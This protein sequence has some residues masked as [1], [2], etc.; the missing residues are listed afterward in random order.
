MKRTYNTKHKRSILINDPSMTAWGY[1]VMSL[2]GTLLKQGCIKTTPADKMLRIRKGDDFVRR[3]GEVN[4]V[5]IDTLIKYNVCYIISELPHGSQSAISAKM[6]G[7]VVG[8][9]KAIGDCF[10]LGI[11][12]YSEGDC[13][14]CVLGK[15]AA[16]KKEMINAIDKLYKVLW[17]GTGYKDEAVADA[18]AV[19]H[20][21]TKNSNTLKLLKS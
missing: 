1:V 21:A 11:E 6:L 5:L 9:I 3:I 14:M 13:K 7:A 10:D 18:L 17:T 15:R 12:W 20:T 8:M 19:Y 2:D 4:N 16:A